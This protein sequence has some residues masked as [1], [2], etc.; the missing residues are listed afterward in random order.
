MHLLLSVSG[1]NC[2]AAATTTT[3]AL[4]TPAIN[5][6]KD[7]CRYFFHASCTGV[8]PLSSRRGHLVKVHFFNRT[9][10]TDELRL[11]YAILSFFPHRATV[12]RERYLLSKAPMRSAGD[13]R[14]ALALCKGVL[15]RVSRRPSSAASPLVSLPT[16]AHISSNRRVKLSFVDSSCRLLRV[17]ICSLS[18]YW[19]FCSRLRL[20]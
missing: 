15:A 11:L 13:D 9:R 12:Q 1:G 7:G 6:A 20:E 19:C 16:M 14:L 8:K 17:N 10:K 2:R 5:K 18:V 4:L 3:I